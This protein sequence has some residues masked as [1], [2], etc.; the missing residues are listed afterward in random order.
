MADKDE[1]GYP[2]DEALQR[3]EEW[4]YAEGF[5]N[6]MRY[7]E[8]LWAYGDCFY[9]DPYNRAYVLVTGGWSGNESVVGALSRNLVFW[10]MCWDSSHRGGK[11]KF[12]LRDI[13]K[14]NDS[15]R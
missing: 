12:T 2:T 8:S 9:R 13:Q 1:H 5:D 14:G 4:P 11:H 15:E 3:I 10:G 6:L 7:V